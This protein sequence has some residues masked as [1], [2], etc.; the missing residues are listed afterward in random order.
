MRHDTV[1]KSVVTVGVWSLV[2]FLVA[3]GCKKEGKQVRKAYESAIEYGE[4]LKEKGPNIKYRKKLPGDVWRYREN[5]EMPGRS[6]LEVELDLPYNAKP[7]AIKAVL[8]KVATK[9]K[10]GTPYKAIRVRAWPRNLRRYG[11]IMGA[12]VLAIDGGGWARERVGYRQMKITLNTSKDAPPPT[13]HEYSLLLRMEEFHQKLLK[14]KKRYRRMAKKRPEK[15]RALVMQ[16][17]A[18]ESGLTTASVEAIAKRAGEFYL[19]VLD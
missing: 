6:R 5:Y 9:A 13:Q 4:S 16:K 3:S 1:F 10:A 11:G 18:A 14:E 19:Q 7:K 8:K 2:A 17:V 12:Y 15:F